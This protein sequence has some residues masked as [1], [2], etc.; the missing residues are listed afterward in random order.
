[1]AGTAASDTRRQHG[2]QRL[3]DGHGWCTREARQQPKRKH[4]PIKLLLRYTHVSNGGVLQIGL[5]SS[6][7]HKR[8]SIPK[9]GLSHSASLLTTGDYDVVAVETLV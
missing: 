7:P 4:W 6:Q 1:M 9:L 2:G 3:V 5:E 8:W